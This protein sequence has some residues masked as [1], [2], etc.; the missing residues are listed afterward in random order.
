MA[1]FWV[2]HRL[3]EMADQGATANQVNAIAAIVNFRTDS[4]AA[5]VANFEVINNRGNFN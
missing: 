1:Y 3:P 2:T 5:R 4:Y